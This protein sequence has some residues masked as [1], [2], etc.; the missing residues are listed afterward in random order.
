MLYQGHEYSWIGFDEIGNW[1]NLNAY[2]KL[3]ACL[4]GT[5]A[6]V[7]HRRIRCTANP[8]GPGHHAVKNY[9]IDHNPSGF[10][11]TKTPEGTTRMFIP[12]KVSD[13]VI[14]MQADPGYVSRLREV[15][16][17][18]L[19]RAWLEGDWNVITGAYFP[20]FSTTQHVIDPVPLPPYLLKYMAG[21][22]GSASPFSF[23][24]Y[25]V[26]DGTIEIP[27]NDILSSYPTRVIP[28]G[29]VIVYRE[30]YGALRGMVNTGLRWPA[31]RVAEG[32]KTR[33]PINE[34]ISFRVLDPSAFKQDGGPSHAETM[35][36][37]GV[38]FRPADN[39]RLAG[40]NAV[41]ERL[42]GLD[43]DPDVNS[44]VGIPMLYIFNTCI[45]LIRTLPALQHDTKNP[46]DCDTTAEDHAPDDLRYACMGRPWTR[47]K[48]MPEPEPPK[49]LQEVTLNDL[50]E[51]R[52]NVRVNYGY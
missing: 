33:T 46:E 44:G 35:A 11:L 10:E 28:K 21:D 22:W 37:A 41:R 5:S 19:V 16:S 47:P 32:I 1:H 49:T 31:S 51:D 7:T 39:T 26:S 25:A 50:F 15:G 14:L 24:W 23:H 3:K 18:E 42:T 20:E 13:N 27:N 4:R 34:K 43:A 36:R 40:W 48:P 17:A 29:A 8:G 12:A 6:Q 45:H 38:F 9:F 30:W 52:Q 2:N